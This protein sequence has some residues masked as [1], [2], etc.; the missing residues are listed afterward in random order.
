MGCGSALHR[1]S[2]L[3]QHIERVFGLPLVIKLNAD[4]PLGSALANRTL[5]D[6]N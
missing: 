3:S 1:N 5:F 4:A 2:V 6:N